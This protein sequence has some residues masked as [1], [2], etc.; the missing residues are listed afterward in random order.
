MNRGI[1]SQSILCSLK[2]T[3][4]PAINI[5]QQQWSNIRIAESNSRSKE[6]SKTKFS[7]THPPLHLFLGRSSKNKLTIPSYS[8]YISQHKYEKDYNLFAGDS[9]SSKS[10]VYILEFS[11]ILHSDFLSFLFCVFFTGLFLHKL[12]SQ[13][14]FLS[15]DPQDRRLLVL[16]EKE[17]DLP[18][19]Y[20]K[21]NDFE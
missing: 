4:I 18:W 3:I 13:S 16:S 20:I 21:T 10:P 15:N 1:S 6:R 11:H 5:I 8:K 19:P 7:I 2:H 12:L 17:S 9:K 14:A